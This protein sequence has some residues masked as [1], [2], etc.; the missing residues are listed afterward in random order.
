MQV[1]FFAIKKNLAV[2]LRSIGVYDLLRNCLPRFLSRLTVMSGE[3]K[4]LTLTETRRRR[5]DFAGLRWQFGRRRLIEGHGS[6]KA[7]AILRN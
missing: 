6:N 5:G 7:L 2:L 1:S 4:S 3:A